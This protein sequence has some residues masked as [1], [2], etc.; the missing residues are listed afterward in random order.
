MLFFTRIIL[1]LFLVLAAVVLVQ[2]LPEGDPLGMKQ[3]TEK[4]RKWIK[5]RTTPQPDAPAHTVEKKPEPQPP[6]T[7]TVV[8]ESE[9]QPETTVTTLPPTAEEEVPVVRR[10]VVYQSRDDD[11]VEAPRKRRVRYES[12]EAEEAYEAP[13]RRRSRITILSREEADAEVGYM[14]DPEPLP[15]QIEAEPDDGYIVA[16]A[17]PPRRH[18]RHKRFTVLGELDRLRH[19]Y[20]RQQKYCPPPARRQRGLGYRVVRPAYSAQYA[21]PYLGARSGYGPARPRRQ[22]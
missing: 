16:A 1:V 19:G 9:R 3:V 14:P 7:P 2:F 18:V 12:I 15:P 20:G 11:P 13:R 21:R 22:Y 5:E 4:S 10:R 8:P 17:P 6:T